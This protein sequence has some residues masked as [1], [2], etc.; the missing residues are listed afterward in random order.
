MAGAPV[1]ACRQNPYRPLDGSRSLRFF[2]E[3]GVVL[4]E[5]ARVARQ[6][7]GGVWRLEKRTDLQGSDLELYEIGTVEDEDAE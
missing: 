1:R 5:A 7:R 6:R 2:E 4:R 3:E